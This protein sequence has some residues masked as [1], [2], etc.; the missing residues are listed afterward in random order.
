M[1]KEKLIIVAKSF[2]VLAIVFALC[3]LIARPVNLVNLDL[4]RHLKNGELI[5]HNLGNLQLLQQLLYTNFY[6]YT[7]Q[8]FPFVMH[9]WG[10]GVIFYIVYS[11]LGISG[12]ELTYILLTCVAFLL[13]FDTTRRFT[14]FW[15]TSGVSIL[16]LPII[17]Y[18]TEV[19]PEVFSVF[20]TSLL[21][22]FLFVLKPK[23]NN[24][25][26]WAVPVLFLVWANIHI[27]FIFG[28]LLAIAF[29][30][31]EGK[32]DKKL[33]IKN[34][35]LVTTSILACCITPFGFKS[36][37]YPFLIFKEYG[38]TIVE[39]KS[40]YF[41]QN[42]GIHNLAYDWYEIA[43][44]ILILGFLVWLVFKTQQ[45]KIQVLLNQKTLLV[46]FC[47]SFAALGFLATRNISQGG[48][49][50]LPL[51]LVLWESLSSIRKKSLWDINK[52]VFTF[53]ILLVTVSINLK[54]NYSNYTRAYIGELPGDRLAAEFIKQN[55]IQG[56][57]FNNYDIGG[58]IIFNL[59]PDIKPFVDNR[60]ESYSY[61]FFQKTY[62]P[63]QQDYN[64]FKEVDKKYNFNAIIF[65]YRD[66]TNWGQDFLQIIIKKPEWVPVFADDQILVML[67][68]NQ[69]NSN[70]IKTYEIQR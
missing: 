5:L 41:L 11:L 30:I 55:N 28:L 24:K 33:R 48:L 7:E 19:R 4:G 47:I 25:W 18:R 13:L 51:S 35:T 14:S 9:H 21:V 39:N 66:L 58:W 59:Y 6:S 64:K 60:P 29:F 56:P 10:G 16:L 1:N 49:L 8:S 44:I 20:L 2:S 46:A 26:V 34:W 40:I 45:Q 37:L 69:Q 3:F 53:L 67:K 57:I 22:W 70:I 38:Y 43:L 12:T 52:A 42:F 65:D 32:L 50:M 23:L 54:Y 27:Y 68:N 62:I 61:D 31:Q 15:W 36:L 63:M 17:S